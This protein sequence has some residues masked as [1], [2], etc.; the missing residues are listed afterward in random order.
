MGL[1]RGPLSLVRIT[2]ELR[3][4]KSS[5]SGSRKSR[6][7]AVRSRG[8]DHATPSIRKVGTNLAD[9]QRLLD[10]CSLHTKATGF[11]CGSN[12]RNRNINSWSV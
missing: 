9:M 8:A 5:G 7:T 10:R 6:L 1:D 11:F 2:E 12:S 4:W 3:E